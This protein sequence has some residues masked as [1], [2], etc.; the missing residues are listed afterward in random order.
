MEIVAAGTAWIA[1]EG[2]KIVVPVT[3]DQGQRHMLVLTARAMAQMRDAMQEAMKT[4]SEARM[5]AR[6][7]TGWKPAENIAP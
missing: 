6:S 5:A 7:R 4:A 2:Y 3:D 1:D